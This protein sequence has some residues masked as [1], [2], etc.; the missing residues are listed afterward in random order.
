[1]S[2]GNVHLLVDNDPGTNCPTEDPSCSPTLSLG[3]QMNP[4]DFDVTFN[5]TDFF[6]E[7]DGDAVAL[8]VRG[9]ADFA[10]VS[11]SV[12]GTDGKLEALIWHDGAATMSTMTV[13]DGAIAEAPMSF[14]AALTAGTLTVSVT[15]QGT[16]AT[17]AGSF[18]WG[19]TT[20]SVSLGLY[21]TA[22]PEQSDINNTIQVVLTGI[23]VANGGN[24]SITLAT[25]TFACDDLT[26]IEGS[27][28]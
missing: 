16:T 20:G 12:V 23:Q 25:D 7:E 22:P 1:M 27:E 28:P 18:S 19:M 10:R 26:V 14:H 6:A 8:F 13:P 3:E 9:D 21:A 24:G 5:T 15:N 2:P 4:A 11:L 17:Q